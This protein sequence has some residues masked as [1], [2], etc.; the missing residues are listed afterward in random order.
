MNILLAPHND[1]EA[2]FC[3]YI[4]QQ[5]N[6]LV[7]VVTDGMNMIHKGI[8][9]EI[10]REETLRAMEI[11]GASVLFLGLHDDKL[12]PSQVAFALKG[13]KPSWVFAPAVYKHGHI[14]HNIVGQVA[15]DLWKDKVIKYATYQVNDFEL[16]GDIAVYP[17]KKEECLKELALKEYRTQNVDGVA[18]VH[19]D[20]VK[21]KPEYFIK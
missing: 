19:F 2:L 10:R 12:T 11:L 9:P 20:A 16:K 13:I 17:T 1:D 14:G 4:I 21:G 7:I 15:L 3:S 18:K 6:P 8:T 5:N